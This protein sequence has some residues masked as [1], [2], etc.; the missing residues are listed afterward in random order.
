MFAVEK[1]PTVG[2]GEFFRIES[3][4]ENNE[5]N[6]VVFLMCNPTVRRPV[7]E[8]FSR[9]VEAVERGRPTK[10]FK[11][12][13]QKSKK[14]DKYQVSIDGVV[15]QSDFETEHEAQ[16]FLRGFVLGFEMGSAGKGLNAADLPS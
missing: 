7:D 10:V 11:A 9:M 8:I 5:N 16:L 6:P 12:E 2:Q 14:D 15:V 13:I 4:E 3:I 1:G